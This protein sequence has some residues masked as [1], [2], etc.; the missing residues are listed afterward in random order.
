VLQNKETWILKPIDGV[1]NIDSEAYRCIRQLAVDHGGW[2]AL[3]LGMGQVTRGMGKVARGTVEVP[4]ELGERGGRGGLA[5]GVCV[6]CGSQEGSS[7]GIGI[8]NQD[9][10]LLLLF[11]GMETSVFF[12]IFS[13]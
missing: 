5:G 3:R 4:L 8:D 10:F 12:R 6:A 13:L 9:W 2:E 7:F 1:E 11:V